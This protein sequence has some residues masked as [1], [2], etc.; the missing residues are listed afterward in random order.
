MAVARASMA[1]SII[2]LD[3]DEDSP[4][5]PRPAHA[6]TSSKRRSAST[7]VLA[8]KEPT[9]AP[10]LT[11]THITAS[12]FASA[13]KEG[14]VLQVENQRLFDEVRPQRAGRPGQGP[15]DRGDQDGGHQTGA[16]GG[17][18]WL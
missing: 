12:P 2:I 13:K 10:T 18:G 4:Q 7:T 16:D 9:P 17:W 5:P 1:E 3:D 8:A 6:I 11:P 15:P 14:H